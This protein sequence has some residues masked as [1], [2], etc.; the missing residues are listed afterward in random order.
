VTDRP[1]IVLVWRAL[2]A[3]ARTPALWVAMGAQAGLYSLYLLVWGDGLPLAGARPVLEQFATAQWIVLSLALPWAAARSGAA[4]RRD[5]IAQFAALGAVLPS[6][7]V[8]AS[9]AAQAVLLLATASVGLPFAVLAQQISAVPL[10]EMWRTQLPLYALG[11]C[12]AAVTPACMLVAANRF[13]AWTAATALSLAAAMIV[14]QGLAGAAVLAALGAGVGAVLV[15]GADRRLW[16]LS[17][18]A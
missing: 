1:V 4:W 12:A 7:I 3:A 10:A 18:H 5:E 8:A 17:E 9:V 2:L 6:S 14:P 11:L 13:L 15:S 16:Y